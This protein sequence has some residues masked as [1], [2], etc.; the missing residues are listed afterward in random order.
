M[1]HFQ[2]RR[3]D[4]TGRGEERR[5]RE[6][7]LDGGRLQRSP[8]GE[9]GEVRLAGLRLRPGRRVGFGESSP[10]AVRLQPG[11]HV[12]M[13]LEEPDQGAVRSTCQ[14]WNVIIV[15]A[16]RHSRS[17]LHVLLVCS[18]SLCCYLYCPCHGV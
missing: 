8:G 3:L 12:S 6:G 1:K 4:G 13:R 7:G 10:A 9:D 11:R 18:V 14:Y 16:A 5:G 15:I 17:C 2:S